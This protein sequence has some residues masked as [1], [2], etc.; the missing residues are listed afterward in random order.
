MKNDKP[1]V[2]HSYSPYRI[3]YMLAYFKASA[4][5]NWRDPN[6]LHIIM[7]ITPELVIGG[8]RRSEHGNPLNSSPNSN[9][10]FGHKTLNPNPKIL[11]HLAL[12]L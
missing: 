10:N 7:N 9:P 8:Y 3:S 11:S 1:R 6:R 12:K 2:V 4:I 5:N